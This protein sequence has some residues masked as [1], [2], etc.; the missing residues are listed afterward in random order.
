MHLKLILCPFYVN[1]FSFRE[2]SYDILKK[3]YFL[4]CENY[5]LK[6]KPSPSI[7]PNI[8]ILFFLFDLINCL[9]Y[10]TGCLI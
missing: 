7:I 9:I 1:E 4:P 2:C 3:I 10:W 5:I 6:N 8:K